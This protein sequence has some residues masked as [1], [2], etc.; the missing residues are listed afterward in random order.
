V[1]ACRI[2]SDKSQAV[3]SAIMDTNVKPIP[4]GYE[5]ATPYLI[6]K[7]AAQAIE[8]YKKAFGAEELMRIPAPENKIGH[9][10]IRIGRAPIM[11]ADEFSDIGFLSPTSLGGSP[12]GVLIYLEDV[13]AVF[14][15]ALAMGADVVKPLVDQF[16]G[17]RAGTIKDPFGHIWTLATR[18]ENLSAATIQQR[19]ASEGPQ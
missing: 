17:D 11:L 14:G 3:P 5:A 4:D 10:E 19:A 7:N 18:K 12:V 9:A 13:D 1:Y 2:D 15:R 8:F 16:Y 6:I